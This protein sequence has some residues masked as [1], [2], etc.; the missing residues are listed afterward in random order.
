MNQRNLLN[1]GLL[2][3]IALLVLL[4]LFEPGIEE[5]T[6]TPTLLA[7]AP[8]AINHIAIQ[9]ENQDAVELAKEG[10]QWWMVKPLRHPA[11]TFR[12]DSLLRITELKSQSSFAATEK[13]L[14][15]YQLEQPRA[16]LI[17]N[18][19]MTLNFGGN[20]PL[21]HRRYVMYDG[22]VHLTTDS[23]YYHLIGSAATFLRK[24]LL[25]EGA[26]IEALSLPG[27]SVSWQETEWQLTPAP[28]SFSADQITRLID[29]WK[30][31][32]AMEIKP[33][34][35]A[36]GEKVSLTLSTGEEPVELLLTAQEPDLI[37]ARPDIGVQYHFASTSSEKLL[38]LPAL[39][40]Q[41]AAV[42]PPSEV[43]EQDDEERR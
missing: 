28:E 21:D 31:A 29:N 10:E 2:A 41:E 15:E 32:A 38:Q 35:G 23:Y 19:T 14:A 9:R 25:D 7:V 33:Y 34:D 39:E 18:G 20:T 17:L 16:S 22:R 6:T 36:G 43:D 26:T 11:D 42:E 5:P 8:E 12:I 3:L 1:L 37:L 40:E 27:L 13:K 30:L 24:R 4:V